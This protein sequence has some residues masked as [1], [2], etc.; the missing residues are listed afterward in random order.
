MRWRVHYHSQGGLV[1][2]GDLVRRVFLPAPGKMI[3]DSG[4]L[5]VPLAETNNPAAQ[6]QA[7]LAGGVMTPPASEN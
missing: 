2:R 6:P 7:Q 5:G 3:F 1:L 4:M